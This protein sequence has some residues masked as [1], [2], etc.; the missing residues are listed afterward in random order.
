[1]VSKLNQMT[2]QDTKAV[3]ASIDSDRQQWAQA[4]TEALTALAD[5]VIEQLKSRGASAAEVDASVHQGLS[6]TVR[7]GEVETLEYS[8]DRG[9]AM[10]VYFGQR[11]G[12]ANS[13]DLSEASIA[14]SIDM[15]C[16][17]ARFTETDPCAGLAD[18]DRMATDQPDLDLW[19]PWSLSAEQGIELATAIEA[20]GLEHDP[21]INNSE[22][23]SINAGSGVS[24][25]ANSYGFVGR[26]R[27]SRQSL[28]CAL[29]AGSGDS[30]QR[31][32]WYDTRRSAADLQDPLSIG[33]VAAER[34]VAR[35]NPRTVATGTVPVLFAPWVARTLLGHFVSAISGSA[36]YR[37]SSFLL[38]QLGQP[39]FPEFVTLQELPFEPR[40]LRSTAYDSEGV[41]T[42]ERKLIDAG[43]LDSYLLS[44][45]SARKLGLESTG[46]AGGTHN[47]TL[48]GGDGDQV[49]LLKQMGRG[50]LVTELM[51][52]GVNIVTGDYSRG[53]SGFWVE[54][55]EIAYPVEGATIAGNL[56]DIFGRI[57]AA[58]GDIDY[59]GGIRCGS[60]LISQ[61]TVAG[62]G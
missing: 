26:R 23:A 53:A 25:Y 60:L 43:V 51:G 42:T 49:S 13:A 18:A 1:M 8:R 6:V 39:L 12:S 37:K 4:E 27:S 38:D 15:A 24:V 58:G 41:A 29:V 11:K 22:G 20:T 10:T 61:M 17:I 55:G 9:F 28:S 48:L 21:L 33:R 5:R 34:T 14:R 47:L 30:M 36:I 44:S 52:Q 50:L 57:E 35:H 62:E 32:Y 31:D 2:V 54:N 46:N 56:R 7:Q 19:H 40:A 59:R 3:L 45:Y 16:D